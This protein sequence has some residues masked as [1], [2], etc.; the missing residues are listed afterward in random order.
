MILSSEIL[1]EKSF[2]SS[3]SLAKPMMDHEEALDLVPVRPKTTNI[4]TGRQ[5]PSMNNDE[6]LTA[7]EERV[8][9]P[10]TTQ[11]LI[12]SNFNFCNLHVQKTSSCSCSLVPQLH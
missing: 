1:R 5:N 11:E 9:R 4:R 3:F 10:K 6:E 12:S 7:N 2:V 8:Q